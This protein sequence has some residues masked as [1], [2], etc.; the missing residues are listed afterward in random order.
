MA[1]R[2]LSAALLLG[3]ALLLIPAP[4]GIVATDSGVL[5]RKE[6]PICT[7]L[8]QDIFGENPEA[9]GCSWP[10]PEKKRH[11]DCLPVFDEERNTRVSVCSG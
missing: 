10:A 11:H 9:F 1:N 5:T 8:L 2:S 7:I 3:M 6:K 4:A